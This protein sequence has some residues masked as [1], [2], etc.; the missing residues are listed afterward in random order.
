[1]FVTVY[2]CG[3]YFWKIAAFYFLFL[4][5]IGFVFLNVKVIWQD[6]TTLHD[7]CVFP[8]DQNKDIKNSVSCSVSILIIESVAT[9]K[10][11]NIVNGCPLT[12]SLARQKGPMEAEDQ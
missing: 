2:K 11:N 8:S 3:A 5:F 6:Q 7:Q 12:I 10:S 1:M 9:D 4:F